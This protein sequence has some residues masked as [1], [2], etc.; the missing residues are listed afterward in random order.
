MNKH[1]L[2]LGLTDHYVQTNEY[3]VKW[4][5][6]NKHCMGTFRTFLVGE[7]ELNI[8]LCVCVCVHLS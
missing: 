3:D 5:Q 2:V 6:T 4:G 7:P 1:Y 8:Q